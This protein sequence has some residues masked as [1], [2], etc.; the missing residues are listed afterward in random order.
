MNF[1]TQCAERDAILYVL[2]VS[3]GGAKTPCLLNTGSMLSMNTE[4]FFL[5][6]FHTHIK[7][8]MQ[9]CSCLQLKAANGLEILYCGYL[10]LEVEVLGRVLPKMGVLITREL[11]LLLVI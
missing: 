11:T 5:S 2:Q 7:D 4:S 3:F 8:R 6:S 10:E 9:P 1:D